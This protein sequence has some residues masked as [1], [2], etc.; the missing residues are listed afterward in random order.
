MKKQQGIRLKNVK[1]E[2]CLWEIGFQEAGEAL[3]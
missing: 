1:G 3:A 2:K